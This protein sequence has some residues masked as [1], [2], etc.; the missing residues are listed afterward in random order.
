MEY[1]ESNELHSKLIREIKENNQKSFS[2]LLQM[3]EPLIKSVS[4]KLLRTFSHTPTELSDLE[5]IV[6]AEFYSL[7]ISYDE[8][9]GTFFPTYVKKY[10]HMRGISFLRKYMNNNNKI[11]NTTYLN[12]DYLDNFSKDENDFSSEVEEMIQ[13]TSTL[14]NFER[15]LLSHILAGYDNKY[16]Q[17]LFGKSKQ[18][19]SN[20]KLTAI[21]KIRKKFNIEI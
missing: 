16:L 14:T 4:K 8:A 10:L 21:N 19:I 18:Y 2:I 3:Y 7:A 5:N 13:K 1:K 17:I 20:S 11:A 6:S 9:K 15:D 12:N